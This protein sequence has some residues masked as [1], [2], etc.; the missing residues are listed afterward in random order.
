MSDWKSLFVAMR[1]NAWD[2]I[3]T[4][5]GMPMAKKMP[6][7]SVGYLAV[8]ESYGKAFVDNPGCQIHEMKILPAEASN[9]N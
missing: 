2:K 1:Y 8:Y 3:T 7:G 4:D 9:E 5:A 6:D